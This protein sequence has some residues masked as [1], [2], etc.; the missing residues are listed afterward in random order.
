M[1]PAELSGR[2]TSST[3]FVPLGSTRFSYPVSGTVLGHRVSREANTQNPQDRGGEES[4]ASQGS[5]GRASGRGRGGA[6]LPSSC[7]I[8]RGRGPGRREE[9]TSA[10]GRSTDA[11]LEAGKQSRWKGEMGALGQE[12]RFLPLERKSRQAPWRRQDLSWN[13]QHKQGTGVLAEGTAQAKAWGQGSSHGWVRGLPGAGLEWPGS[14]Q[15][16]SHRAGCQRGKA[17]PDLKG[18][19]GASERERARAWW[20]SRERG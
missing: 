9:P 19:R 10:A 14:R 13:L 1:V 18:N 11:L 15:G 17:G 20:G 3:S 2:P 16:P 5:E 6:L 12:K 8:G 7:R 4:W